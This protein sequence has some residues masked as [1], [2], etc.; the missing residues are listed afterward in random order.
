MRPRRASGERVVLQ[1][2][3][4][5]D[6]ERAVSVEHAI[7][8]LEEFGPGARLLAGGHSL[9][10]MMKL[11]LA[12][13][14][15]VIDID[16]LAGD[17]GYIREQDGEIRIGAMTTSGTARRSFIIGSREW[18]PASSRAPGPNSSSSAIACSTLTA[19]S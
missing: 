15:V 2:P 16:P 1:V 7:A 6:Y 3:A 4:P 13:P 14:D 5:F 18:P 9:L 19:R 12:V 8:L 11:R 17:L 10:P